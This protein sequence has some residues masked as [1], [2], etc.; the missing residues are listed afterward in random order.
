MEHHLWDVRIARA[1]FY[2]SLLLAVIVAWDVEA[3]GPTTPP[4]EGT[5]TMAAPP[6][7]KPISEGLALRL[8]NLELRILVLQREQQ[9]LALDE[10]RRLGLDLARW[11]LDLTARVWRPKP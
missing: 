11:D 10:A 2:G 1:A 5:I 3:Q 4:P 9:L 6:A 8:E 7:P